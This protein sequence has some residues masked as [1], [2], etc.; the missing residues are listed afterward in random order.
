MRYLGNE[1]SGVC[2]V[3]KELNWYNCFAFMR[4]VRK[5]G[6]RRRRESGGGLPLGGEAPARR[7]DERGIG[8]SAHSD[9]SA[10]RRRGKQEC[11]ILEGA[12]TKALNNRALII[13]NA[14]NNW[15]QLKSL[16]LKYP[17]TGLFLSR[18]RSSSHQ[19]SPFKLMTTISRT[20]SHPGRS[21]IPSTVNSSTYPR[22]SPRGHISSL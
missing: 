14:P 13:T 12:L 22:H 1:G 3:F 15:D 9:G 4:V 5:G 17:S 8:G 16:H 6:A 2:T 11:P 21:P 19:S 10:A 7:N 18:A 20:S